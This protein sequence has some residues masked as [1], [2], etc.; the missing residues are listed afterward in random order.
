MS[1]DIEAENRKARKYEAIMSEKMIP[2]EETL[3]QDLQKAGEKVENQL[4]K[5]IQLDPDLEEYRISGT[6]EDWDRA[7]K[8]GANGLVS[9]PLSKKRDNKDVSLEKPNAK[10]SKKG[11]KHHGKH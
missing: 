8:K 7:L 2:L 11:K 3:S 6:Q 4:S 1:K 9:I 5:K 10:K